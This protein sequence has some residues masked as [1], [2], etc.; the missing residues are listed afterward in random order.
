M[1]D[2]LIYNAIKHNPKGTIIWVYLEKDQE[3]NMLTIT[4]E[5]IKNH[6][7]LLIKMDRCL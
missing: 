5:G 2:N 6:G 3:K 7:N 1:I 4:I